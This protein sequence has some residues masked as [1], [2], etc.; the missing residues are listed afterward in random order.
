MPAGVKRAHGK[1]VL[2]STISTKPRAS[3]DWI[4]APTFGVPFCGP[5]PQRRRKNPSC[6]ERAPPHR[7]INSR[8]MRS[9]SLAMNRSGVPASSGVS[10]DI[11]PLSHFRQ[12]RFPRQPPQFGRWRVLGLGGWGDEGK[13]Y[14]TLS[15][16]ARAP[17]RRFLGGNR[18]GLRRSFPR[19]LFWV[20]CCGPFP[21]SPKVGASS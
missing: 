9:R 14:S 5:L 11:K 10:I 16:G 6:S 4:V 19:R 13:G 12:D 15:R 2:G 3:I 20:G 17:L 8:R 21:W 1:P 18:E 7:T